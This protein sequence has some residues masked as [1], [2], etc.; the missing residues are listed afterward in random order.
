MH[1]GC[2]CSQLTYPCVLYGHKGAP[3]ASVWHTKGLNKAPLSDEGWTW[4]SHYHAWPKKGNSRKHY[5][6][7]KRLI[8]FPEDPLLVCC[9]EDRVRT[10]ITDIC[11]SCQADYFKLLFFFVLLLS[12][13]S[14][15]G[16][17]VGENKSTCSSK[18]DCSSS[19]K[20]NQGDQKWPHPQRINASSFVLL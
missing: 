9:G 6:H 12:S 7:Q 5:D 15:P 17:S 16:S 11:M 20:H 2:H 13:D 14:V 10:E 18:C 8:S 3:L 19:G 1:L 4:R